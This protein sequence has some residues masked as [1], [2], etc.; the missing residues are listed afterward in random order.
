MSPQY[1][2]AIIGARPAGA[3]T[4]MLLARRG[5][6]VLVLDRT[7]RG[8]DTLST[9]AIMRVGVLLLERWGLLDRLLDAGTPPLHAVTFDYGDRPPVRVD[10]AAPL[11]APRRTVLDAMLADAAAEAGADVRHGVH[12]TGL[13]RDRAGRVIGVRALDRD[14]SESEVQARL[15]VGADGR[16]SLVAHEVAAP[17]TRQG[18]VAAAAMY[19]FV[20]GVETDGLEWLY[21]PGASAG[22]IPT[23]AGEA[24]VFVG[25]DPDRYLRELRSD[26]EGGFMRLLQEVSPAAAERVG[27]A[28]RT[29]PVRGFPGQVGWLRRPHGPGWA[30]VG[31][32]GYFKDPATAHGI[33]DALRDAHLLAEAADDGLTGRRPMAEAMASYER[34]RDELSVP[35][36]EVTERIA[37]P[38]WTLDELADLHRELSAAMKREVV[39]LEGS[40]T[41]ASAA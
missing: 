14:G 38:T 9:L 22:I 17:V 4:A 1:D 32:A 40:T 30:L 10:L 12:A 3:S 26:Q 36:F 13:L 8:S 35:L 25:T 21:A 6:R 7:R 15:V 20:R 29:A 27:S 18:S 16:G 11:I 33:A 34:V 23:T 24:C 31:D 5:H 28:E 37:V 39:H 2:V 19:T 41:A